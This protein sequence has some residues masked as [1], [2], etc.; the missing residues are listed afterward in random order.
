MS[1]DVF[2]DNTPGHGN[3][4]RVSVP[5]VEQMIDE[6]ICQPH[7]DHKS[8]AFNTFFYTRDSQRIL[9]VR[10]SYTKYV[11]SMSQVMLYIEITVTT[12]SGKLINNLITARKLND[13]YQY[14]NDE[15]IVSISKDIYHMQNAS[16]L[17]NHMSRIRRSN[18]TGLE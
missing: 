11:T 12:E 17:T 18:N 6:W 1:D 13:M 2:I 15:N 8:Y 9:T 10:I 3:P 7:T 4:A 16:E 5:E 14:R